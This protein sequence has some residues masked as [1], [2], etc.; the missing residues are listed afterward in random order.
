MR[1][2][3]LFL[4]LPLHTHVSIALPAGASLLLCRSHWPHRSPGNPGA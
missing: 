3:A 2:L 4:L 1:V